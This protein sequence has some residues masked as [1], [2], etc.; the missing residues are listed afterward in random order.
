MEK[1]NYHTN[2]IILFKWLFYLYNL[3]S[4]HFFFASFMF[5]AFSARTLISVVSQDS[6]LV[7]CSFPSVPF[8]G[9][10]LLLSR[11]WLP[12]TYLEVRNTFSSAIYSEVQNH[13]L[14]YLK[15][16]ALGASPKIPIQFVIFLKT[17]T[18]IVLS[19]FRNASVYAVT[20]A[21]IL[22]ETDSSF[23]LTPQPTTILWLYLLFN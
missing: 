10:P 6:F 8:L 19:K 15:K 18:P 16:A 17:F 3:F 4:H 12:F 11:F 14:S 22:R 21:R 13:I 23:C 1:I 20:Q 2:I 7:H 5:L 9:L